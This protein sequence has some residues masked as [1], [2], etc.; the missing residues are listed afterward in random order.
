MSLSQMT[1]I[2][3]ASAFVATVLNK[4]DGPFKMWAILRHR[5]PF[6]CILCGCFW[7]GLTF[8]LTYCYWYSQDVKLFDALG[9]V[10]MSLYVAGGLFVESD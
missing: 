10:G 4:K 5:K 8:Y 6:N 1:A 9:I 7:M 3:F 2:A